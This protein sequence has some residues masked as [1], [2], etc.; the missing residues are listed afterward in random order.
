MFAQTVPF[1]QV[2]VINNH[3]TDGT[4]A[5]L[6]QLEYPEL[7]THHLTKNLGGAGGFAKGLEEAEKYQLDWIVSIDD[8]AML[9]QHYLEYLMQY[10][11]AHPKCVA[12]SGT[13]RTNGK[14][15]GIHRRKVVSKLLFLEKNISQRE[16]QKEYFHCDC[17]T[18]CGL[19]IRRDVIGQIG[20]PNAGYFLW[21]DDTE[22]SL[23]LRKM[24]G[25]INVS[26]AYL[27]H[28]VELP[29]EK[30]GVL[31]R[32]TWRHYYGCRNRYDVAKRHF[33]KL[34][35]RMVSLEYHMLIG[36]SYLMSLYAGKHQHARFNIQMIHDALSDAENGRFGFNEK[37]WS[38]NK[39]VEMFSSKYSDQMAESTHRHLVIKKN[40]SSPD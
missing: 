27:N 35:A 22:Y 8:D 26:A 2:I 7:T 31:E 40:F 1:A 14:I 38:D 33:G 5:Y 36:M 25:V 20:L 23:R 24:G 18:F 15:Q 12:M 3:S 21:Y 4:K 13:V 30:Q 11:S 29:T 34:S 16:Y 6:E 32:T 17:A 10:A 39:K 9:N 28:K 37:Y 19:T